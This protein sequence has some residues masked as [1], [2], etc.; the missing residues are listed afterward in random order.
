MRTD[1]DRRCIGLDLLKAIAVACIVLHHYQQIA[2]V[3]FPTGINFFGAP[4][5][6]QTEY[7]F[8]WLTILFFMI[9]GFLAGQQ[10]MR[11]SVVRSVPAQI[12]HKCL[13]LY[14]M[15][16]LACA[17]YVGIGCLHR[18]LL[19]DWYWPFGGG[20]L[21][22]IFN[23]A[24][25]TFANGT[26]ALPGIADNNVTCY[27]SVLLNCCLIFY[28]LVWLG[29]RVR[30]GW[31]WLCLLFFALVCSLKTFGV[32]WPLLSV[33][34]GLCEGYIP[35]FLGV[36]LAVAAPYI[37]RRAKYAALILPFVCLAVIFGPFP[38]SWVE[39]QWWMQAF[40][41]YPPLVLAA[42]TWKGHGGTF[43]R[44]VC[45]LGQSSFAVYLWHG[46]LYSLWALAQRLLGMQ[47]AGTRGEMLLFLLAAEALGAALFAFVERPLARYTR[48][49]EWDKLKIVD[50]V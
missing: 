40:M 9:S 17:V 22:T 19:G 27:L 24:L 23:S 18:L 46:P 25:L 1:A 2:G 34:E 36:L 45:F 15:A 10:Q 47:P 37:P 43:E 48:R 14:P 50:P 30:V 31:H 35:F 26:V 33:Q 20:G 5:L 16:I 38:A 11:Q 28:I 29:R 49:W 3:S 42:S 39:N 41:I 7:V 6:F 44:V 4:D 21:W 13:R 8:G 32:T 12:W